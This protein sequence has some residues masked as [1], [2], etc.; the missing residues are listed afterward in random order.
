MKSIDFKAKKAKR[1][2]ETSVKNQIIMIYKLKW[3]KIHGRESATGN[4]IQIISQSRQNALII[5]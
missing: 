2:E 4:L 1:N 3:E 5:K